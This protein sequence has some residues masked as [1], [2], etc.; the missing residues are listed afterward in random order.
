MMMEGPSLEDSLQQALIEA[1]KNGHY[2]VWVKFLNR[3]VQ[4]TR[5]PLRL[6]MIHYSS[7]KI[8]N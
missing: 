4:C 8:S 1:I 3:R 6:A 2:Q 7:R 5:I